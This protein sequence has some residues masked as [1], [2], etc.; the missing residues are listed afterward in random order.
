[1]VGLKSTLKK[2]TNHSLHP[3]HYNKSYNY[4][5]NSATSLYYITTTPLPLHNA[6]PSSISSLH[7][8]LFLFTFEHVSSSSSRPSPDLHASIRTETIAYLKNYAIGETPSIS[9]GGALMEA[10]KILKEIQMRN[11]TQFDEDAEVELRYRGGCVV[12]CGI[13]VLSWVV[14]YFGPVLVPFL[15]V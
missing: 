8:S 13:L 3:P 5:Y 6:W 4:R 9:V 12:F 2:A 7:I 15:M 14:W 10:E 1:M 11:F